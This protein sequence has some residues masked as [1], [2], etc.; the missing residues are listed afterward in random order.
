MGK[1][2]LKKF[3]KYKSFP[4]CYENLSF[5]HPQLLDTH[6]QAV[7]LAGQWKSA[8]NVKGGDLILELA[9]G[10]G[11]YTVGMAEH[12]PDNGY[13]GVDIKG[14]RMHQGAGFVDEKKLNNAA[15]IRSRI[16][17][18][19][20]FFSPG[21]VDGIFIIFPNPLPLTRNTSNCHLCL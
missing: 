20:H 13:I 21:E 3:A 15:F 8:T 12:Y 14:A 4:F 10:K 2:K 7:N 6:N 19:E 9:C 17:L 16:E 11:E 5:D 1:D 18:I